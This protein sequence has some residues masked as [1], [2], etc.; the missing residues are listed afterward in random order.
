MLGM[1]T[2]VGSVA[3]YAVVTVL[4]VACAGHLLRPAAL[5]T[6][7]AAH[8]VLPVRAGVA[9]L[10]TAAEGLLGVA[11]AVALSRGRG[12]GLLLVALAGAALLLGL[13]G[14]Y[15]WYVISTGRGGPCG[16][17]RLELPM[18][19]WV[20]ARAVALAALALV[21]LALSDSVLPL[22]RPGTG[23]AVVLLAAASFAFLLWQLPAA[24]H[25]PG[26]AG[27]PPVVAAAG[28]R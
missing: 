9:A 28:R 23:L 11:G 6:A 20:V 21:A 8:G 2:L 26:R 18:T 12:G 27:L 5:P 25:D 16:C 4:L 19:G 1:S 24:M 10:V 3:A 13:A 17:S 14:A 15:G 7:L 22:V